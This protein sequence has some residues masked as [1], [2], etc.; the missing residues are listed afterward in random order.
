M[1]LVELRLLKRPPPCE[2]PPILKFVRVLFEFDM[3]CRF[4]N[5]L[6]VSYF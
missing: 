2:V 6:F 1:I 4:S 3:K 5:Y